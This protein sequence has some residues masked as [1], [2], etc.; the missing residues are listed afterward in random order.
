MNVTLFLN[1]KGLVWGEDDK[2]ISCDQGGYLC[3]ANVE[4][5]VSPGGDNILP[6][7]F[8]GASG[9]YPAIYKTTDNVVYDL[10]KITVHKGRIVSASRA[11]VELMEL[12]CR[13][14]R[15]EIERDEM[16]RDIEDLRQIFDTNSL[17]FL[18]K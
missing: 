17:N 3:I 2:R 4:I 18:I 16:K 13:E 9:S 5:S 6:L 10:G 7:L 14:D 8:Y 11:E 1:K 12:H 15:A